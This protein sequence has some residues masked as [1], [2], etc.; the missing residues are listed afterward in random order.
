MSFLTRTYAF[1][2][3]LFVLS[4]LVP[5]GAAATPSA[6]QD[7][8]ADGLRAPVSVHTVEG[9]LTSAYRKLG[10][11]SRSELEPLLRPSR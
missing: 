4:V 9:Q 6:P 11:S 1:R 3:A 10:V 7:S 2:A 8:L 5:A